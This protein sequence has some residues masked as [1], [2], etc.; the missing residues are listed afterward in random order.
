MICGV[1]AFQHGKLKTILNPAGHARNFMSNAILLDMAGIP[2]AK[3]P[4]YLTRAGKE[5][6]DKG[7]YYKEIKENTTI[8]LIHS[9]RLKRCNLINRDYIKLLLT[10]PVIF[11]KEMKY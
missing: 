6:L 9:N 1:K 7:K 3:V 11:I 2:T 4:V 8:M 5:M 10:K